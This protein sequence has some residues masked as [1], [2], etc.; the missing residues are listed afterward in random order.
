MLSEAHRRI[1][2]EPN[3]SP[4]ALKM[5]RLD[6]VRLDVG[7]IP[8]QDALVDCFH[9]GVA[10]HCWPALDATALEIYYVVKPGGHYFATTFLSTYFSTLSAVDGQATSTSTSQQAFQYFESVDT[11]RWLLEQGGFEREKIMIEVL[12]AACIVI[13]A[14]K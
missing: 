2:A 3:I 4:N 1:T 6:L 7:R 14:E 10:M 12:G 8:M 13:R 9:A 11:L 5:T